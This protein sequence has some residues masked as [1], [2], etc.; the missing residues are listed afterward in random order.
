MIEGVEEFGAELEIHAFSPE[1][2]PKHEIPV[3][4]ARPVE[5]IA[6]GIS[7][8]AFRR[9]RERCNIQVNRLVGRVL[10]DG[11]YGCHKERVV[12]ETVGDIGTVT[13]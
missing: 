5:V 11:S 6:R 1:I 8:G 12:V 3:L 10:D 2:L 9:R 4:C 7:E 13:R